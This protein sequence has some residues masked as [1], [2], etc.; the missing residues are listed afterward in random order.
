MFPRKQA[1]FNWSG[2][3]DSSLALHYLL[4]SGE[5]D[6]QQLVT[7]VNSVQ[8][9]ISMH[10]VRRELLQLQAESIGI[11]VHAILLPDSP[12]MSEYEQEMERQMQ[13][14][15]DA[16]LHY[17]IFGDIF[18]EDLRKYREDK[19][20]EKGL[21]AVFPLWKRDTGELV[22]TFIDLGFKTVIVCVQAEK[23]DASFAGRTI[24]RKFLEDLP[25]DVDPCGE[26]GE[27]HTFVYDGPIFSKPV[28]FNLGERIFKTYDS[29]ND[30]NDN[31]GASDR[32]AQN[33]FHYIDLETV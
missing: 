29:P 21:T 23:L 32:K 27:F 22:E 3:K 6:I 5:Y 7:T 14:L 17:S 12:S 9:R 26:N 15:I 33:G 16:G 2:G 19:L 24:D 1:Y 11:P 25:A 18:L 28:E 10:G 20:K 30:E 8:G 4:Q 13:P 31:C